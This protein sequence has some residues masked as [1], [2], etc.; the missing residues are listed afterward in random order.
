MTD[1]SPSFGINLLLWPEHMLADP[2]PVFEALRALGYDGIEVPV[3]PNSPTNWQTITTALAA[4][5]LRA[6]VTA[7]GLPDADLSSRDKAIR[8]RGVDRVKA[9]IDIAAG[10]RAEVVAGPVHCAPGVFGEGPLTDPD[11]RHLTDGLAVS[12]AHA[13]DA[14]IILCPEILNR[15][16]SR[17]PNTLAQCR[18]LAQIMEKPDYGFH[19]DTYHAHIEERTPGSSIK[20]HAA[21]VGHVHFSESDRGALG[22]GQ[23]AWAETAAALRSIDYVGWITAE[24]FCQENTG[25]AQ[26]MRLWRPL[27][28]TPEDYAAAALAHMRGLWTSET[29][30]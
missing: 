4:T 20:E 15:Y 16:E 14:G 26:A 8:T 3:D 23:V 7:C 24:A 21:Q 6:S 13:Q 12:Q 1:A 30:I 9:V 11:L 29:T 5:G 17:Y 22:K 18:D 28:G 19:Y 25:L 10:L 27:I 2:E